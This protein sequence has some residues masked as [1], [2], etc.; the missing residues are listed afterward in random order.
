MIDQN[1]QNKKKRNSLTWHCCGPCLVG[2]AV[3]GLGFLTIVGAVFAIAVTF[4]VVVVTIGLDVS[5]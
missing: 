2:D 1:F 4:A 3:F 5:L